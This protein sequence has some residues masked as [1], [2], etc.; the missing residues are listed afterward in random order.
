MET[1]HTINSVSWNSFHV[2]LFVSWPSSVSIN[3]DLSFILCIYE[4]IHVL[5]IFCV[6]VCEFILCKNK[7]WWLDAIVE[8]NDWAIVHKIT[9]QYKLRCMHMRVPCKNKGTPSIVCKTRK[10]YL[11]KWWMSRIF[12]AENKKYKCLR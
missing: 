11:E 5:N 12:L 2:V 9:M 8:K 10:T 4:D 6:C 1:T 7:W 3:R